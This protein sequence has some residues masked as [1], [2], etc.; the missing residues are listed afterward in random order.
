MKTSEIA[1][2]TKPSLTLEH[3]RRFI[4]DTEFQR[5]IHSID[6]SR[7]SEGW[8]SL[9]VMSLQPEEGKTFMTAALGVG[10][11]ELLGKRVLLVDASNP[12]SDWDLDDVFNNH[13]PQESAHSEVIL[14]TVSTG[15]DAI[16]LAGFR[17]LGLKAQEYRV[18]D[19]LVDYKSKYDLI[20]FD[21]A[22]LGTAQRGNFDPWVIA[23]RT[24]ASLLIN[25]K[26]SGDSLLA[27]TTEPFSRIKFIGVIENKGV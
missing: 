20:L 27:G 9:S 16:K 19:I 5:I 7:R 10:F 3:I 15:V 21:S 12:T 11:A 24:D 26:K 14:K 1:S 17:P 8:H 13:D 4:H 2:V 23:A 6:F 25:S 22:A 18:Q